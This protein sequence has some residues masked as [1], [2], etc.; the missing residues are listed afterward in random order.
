MLKKSCSEELFQKTLLRRLVSEAVIVDV[1]HP[2]HPRPPGLPGRTGLLDRSSQAA[3]PWFSAVA[4]VKP[5]RS[6]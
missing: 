4:S 6:D 1:G 3:K 5:E 2:G